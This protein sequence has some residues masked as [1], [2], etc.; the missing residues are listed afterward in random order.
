[1]CV[2]H[3]GWRAH[4]GIY[5]FSVVGD[6]TKNV[7]R[8]FCCFVTKLWTVAAESQRVWRM[9]TLF[10]HMRVTMGTHIL[11]EVLLVL[12]CS[13]KAT[14][15]SYLWMV[16]IRMVITVSSLHKRVQGLKANHSSKQ[17][18]STLSTTK[19][20]TYCKQTESVLST[21]KAPT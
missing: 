7:E 4:V 20:P 11:I 14:L 12:P 15:G 18:E 10:R 17:T 2:P 13:R 16:G 9:K 6:F 21:T 8:S 1:M 19:A 5:C 3:L